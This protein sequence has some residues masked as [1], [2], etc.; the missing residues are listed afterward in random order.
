MY[1]G[2]SFGRPT[3][4]QGWMNT[5]EVDKKIVKMMVE[6]K[7][8]SY[9]AAE[10][11]HFVVGVSYFETYFTTFHSTLSR[12]FFFKSIFTLEKPHV[13]ICPLCSQFS[14]IHILS[15]PAI[16]TKAFIEF[17]KVQR[18]VPQLAFCRVSDV[19]VDPSISSS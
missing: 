17:G 15:F 1:L 9:R 16:V 11:L 2:A 19:D 10:V 7:I 14:H 3:P 5:M 13:L 18:R 12:I 8:K 6:Q 4:P